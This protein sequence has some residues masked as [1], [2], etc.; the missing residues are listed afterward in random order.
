MFIVSDDDFDY[1]V[2][3]EMGVDDF[4]NKLIKFRVFLVWICMLMCWEE[5]IFVSVDVIYLL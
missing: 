4:V 1:V 2:V 3:F 5:W